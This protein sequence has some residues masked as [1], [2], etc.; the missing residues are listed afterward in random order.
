M[1]RIDKLKNGKFPYVMGHPEAILSTELWTIFKG[2]PWQSSRIFIVVDE[3][4]CVVKWGGSFRPAYLEI[5]KLKSVFP[6]S[7][8]LALTATATKSLMKEVIVHLHMKNPTVIADN[9]DRSN[10]Y[11]QMIRL[12]VSKKSAVEIFA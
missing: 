11:I 12:E 1:H 2:K 7:N 8:V 5:K 4:H 3:C 9:M 6:H 10:I